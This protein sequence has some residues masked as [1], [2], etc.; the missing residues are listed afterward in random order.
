[1]FKQPTLL[2]TVLQCE[3]DSVECVSFS[4]WFTVMVLCIRAQVSA[5]PEKVQRHVGTL[6][7]QHQTAAQTMVSTGERGISQSRT[8]Y[9]VTR[10]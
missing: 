1:M 9:K 4:S 5:D 8:I 3:R 10:N 7:A 6:H 2:M